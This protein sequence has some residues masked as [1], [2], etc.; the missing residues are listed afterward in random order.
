MSEGTHRLAYKTRLGR[1]FQGDARSLLHSRNVRPGSVDLIFTSPPFALT[2][3]K[4]YG[5]RDAK[6]YV[7]W[8]ETF[9]PG[10][11]RIM[12]NTGSLVVD[13]GGAYLPGGRRSTYHFE[14]A[15]MLSKHFDLCQE[16]YWY[17]PAKLPSP[18]EWVNV[19]RIRVKDSVNMVLWFSKDALKTKADN[20]RVL[21]RYSESM[22]SLLKNGYQVR[23]RPSNHDITDK[24]A[25]DQG[26]AIQANLL[27]FAGDDPDDALEGAP[28]EAAFDN[29]LSIANTASNDPYLK[30]CRK[31][32]LKPHPARFPPGLASF[33]IEFLTREGDL[34]CDPFAGS[35]VTG[36]SAESTKRRWLSCDLDGEG[37]YAGTYVRTSAFRF[38][39][40]KLQPG[41]RSVPKGNWSSTPHR[42]AAAK[43]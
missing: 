15:V 5:N 10:F 17:N 2:F 42:A 7:S 26:G 12:A 33:F 34:V 1:A 36:A 31:H 13:I 11:D 37:K 14:L 3:P 27:G 32:G 43:T 16:F 40:A 25:R 28:F 4:D 24:F 38:L 41:F 30:A 35:N 9:V 29:V 22:L 19:R 39:N 6:D 20:R 18:A 8:F 21:R 23:K